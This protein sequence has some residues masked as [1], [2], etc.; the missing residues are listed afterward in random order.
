MKLP[1][2]TGVRWQRKLREKGSIALDVQGRP[3]GHEKLATHRGFIEELV[4]QDGD[5]TF[6][7]LAGALEAAT[8]VVAHFASIGRLLRKLRYAYNK[9]HWSRPNGSGRA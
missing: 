9:S 3:P 4:G 2:A 7:E 8:G 1:A 6:L 5:I